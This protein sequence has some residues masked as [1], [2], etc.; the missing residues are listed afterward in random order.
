M[1]NYVALLMHMGYSKDQ[2]DARLKR[3]APEMF[4]STDKQVK[5]E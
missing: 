5:E 2:V 1:A 3:L 4:E